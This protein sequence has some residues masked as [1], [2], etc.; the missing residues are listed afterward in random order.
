MI[1]IR[2]GESEF[3]V[4]FKKTR[5][6]PGI[7]DPKLTPAGRAQIEAAVAQLQGRQCTRIMTSPYART[8]ESA[9]ILAAALDLPIAVDPTIGERAAFACD[10]GSPGSD[11]RKRWPDLALHHIEETWWP[12]LVESDEALDTRCLAFR[13]GMNDAGDW[14]GT[15][16]V[17]HWG[18]IR[19]LTGHRVENAQLVEFDPTAAHPGGGS[20]VSSERPC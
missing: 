8:L 10:V 4:V 6:D 9:V 7:R 18:F 13:N 3:N 15:L 2:H 12:P 11:L 20:V 17:S 16:V 1:L 5:V 14:R 19:G